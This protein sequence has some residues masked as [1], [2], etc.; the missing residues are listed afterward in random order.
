[1]FEFIQEA[2][3]LHNL[4]LT[5][6]L[7]MVLLYWMMVMIGALDFE[8][9]IDVPDLPD[10]DTGPPG[11]NL[12]HSGDLSGVMVLA[13]RFFGFGQVPIAVWGSFFL[14]FLWGFAIILNHRF[15]GE[16]G[17]R[18][19]ATAAWLLLPGGLASLVLTKVVTLPLATLFAAM[20]S[21][22][23]GATTI[24][25]NTGTVNTTGLD[26]SHGQVE[27]KGSGAPA[28]I[29]ARL[30]KAGPALQKGDRVRVV[31]MASEGTFYYVEPV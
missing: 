23:T 7:G 6:L 17:D 11:M 12:H 18:S 15:N 29:N 30:L 19:M 26:D 25:G 28:L 2:L 20:S 3:S 8:G 16:S 31:E 5:A 24:V 13:G 27:I 1:M 10:G 4:P 21:V 22:S 14:L 9:D